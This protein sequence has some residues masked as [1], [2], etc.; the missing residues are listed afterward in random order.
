MIGWPADLSSL[1]PEPT[2]EFY[3]RYYGPEH[4]VV[5]AVGAVD[6]DAFFAQAARYF[7]DLPAGGGG[8]SV[9]TIEPPQRGAKRVEVRFDAQPRLIVAYHKP[10]LPH[11][12]DY[13]FDVIDALLSDGRSSRLVRERREERQAHA[14]H[15][16]EAKTP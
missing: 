10:T 7:G 12:D 8:R 11:R 2:R 15:A 5:V 13:V 4:L 16:I 1:D 6:P 3:R 14:L 9:A